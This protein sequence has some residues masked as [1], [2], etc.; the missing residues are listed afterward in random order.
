MLVKGWNPFMDLQTESIRSLPVWVQLH[1]L[2]IKNWGTDSLSKIGSIL[3]IPLKT[4]KFTKDRQ[5]IRYARLLVEMQIDGPFPEYIEFFNEDGIL[6]RQQVTYE[7]IP[8]KC[9]HCAMLGHSEDVCK[10]KG[11]IRTEWRQKSQAPTQPI[12]NPRQMSI[13]TPPESPNQLMS[14]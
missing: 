6:I 1:A 11:V 8:T 3:G 4:D 9:A 10:K 12:V 7:W 13:P 14:Q 5:V 2:D